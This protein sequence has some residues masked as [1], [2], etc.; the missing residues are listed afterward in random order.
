MGYADEGGRYI[1]VTEPEWD[2]RKMTYFA[3]TQ[4]LALT[5]FG[6]VGGAVMFATQRF[7]VRFPC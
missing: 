3:A 6:V 1:Y 5:I 7:K 2:Y 4:S